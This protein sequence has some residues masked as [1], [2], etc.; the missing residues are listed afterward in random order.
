VV[1]SRFVCQ[2]PMDRGRL[3]DF[4]MGSGRRFASYRVRGDDVPVRL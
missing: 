4:S 1:A 3:C 2:D